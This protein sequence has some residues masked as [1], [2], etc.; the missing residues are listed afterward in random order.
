MDDN[1]GNR[2]DW[3][4]GLNRLVRCWRRGLGC[5]SGGGRL[6]GVHRLRLRIHRDIGH[7]AFHA[8]RRQ[9]DKAR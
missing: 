3:L 9:G 4:N 1:G 6:D 8:A 5:G 2:L 7:P